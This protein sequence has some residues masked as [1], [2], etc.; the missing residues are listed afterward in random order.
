MLINSINLSKPFPTFL[1]II[2]A[3]T[4]SSSFKAGRAATESL[5]ALFDRTKHQR[6]DMLDSAVPLKWPLLG[7]GA[8]QNRL[9]QLNWTL[10][11]AAI[12][13]GSLCLM[14][15]NKGQILRAH[16][17]HFTVQKTWRLLWQQGKIFIVSK[18]KAFTNYVKVLIKCSHSDHISW[19]FAVRNKCFKKNQTLVFLSH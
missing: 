5:R 18:S 6:I 2:R 13:E 11:P 8:S 7:N 12:R 9:Q 19:V 3:Q 1:Q 4:K 10:V 15:M 17:E 16:A 14:R